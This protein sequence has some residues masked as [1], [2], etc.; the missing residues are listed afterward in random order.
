[1][2]AFIPLFIFVYVYGF[3]FLFVHFIYH[4]FSYVIYTMLEFYLIAEK[5][6]QMYGLTLLDLTS[7]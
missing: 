1:M 7:M 2:P 4:T 5:P 6:W 3:C